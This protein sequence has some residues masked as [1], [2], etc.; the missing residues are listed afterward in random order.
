MRK[1]FLLISGLPG[2]GKTT[3]AYQLS[4]A[5]SLSVIDKDEILDQLFNTK[6]VGDSAWRRKLSRDSDIIL[7]QKAIASSGA[8]LSSFW[9]VP[10][11]PMDSGTPTEWIDPLTYQVVTVH[12]DCD[13]K[14]AAER[15]L[16]RKRHNGH[17]D[18]DSSYEK[19]V[20]NFEQLNQLESLII[21]ERVIV[22]TTSTLNLEPIVQQIRKH[23]HAA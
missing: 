9:H 16:Q 13:I 23:L 7:Q 4:A 14:K 3:L 6:G 10:G 12:C 8:I 15:F 2:S 17:L 18:Q 1:I 5:F 20:S 19:L 22:N 11:M 21:G